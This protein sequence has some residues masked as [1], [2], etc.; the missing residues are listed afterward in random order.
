MV[1]APQA[2]GQPAPDIWKWCADITEEFRTFERCELAAFADR[3]LAIVEWT[4]RCLGNPRG[5]TRPAD[6]LAILIARHEPVP[7]IPEGNQD[8]PR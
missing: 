8:E 1:E 5:T 7:S 2:G 3:D 6:V 4:V